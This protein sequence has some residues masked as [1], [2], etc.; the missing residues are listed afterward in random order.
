MRDLLAIQVSFV[1]VKWH[2]WTTGQS[3]GFFLFGFFFGELLG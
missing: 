3:Q 1:D 2:F